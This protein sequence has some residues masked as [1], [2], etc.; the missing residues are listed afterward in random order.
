MTCI[1]MDCDGQATTSNGGTGTDVFGYYFRDR[2]GDGIGL[3]N[4]GYRCSSDIEG[5]SAITGDLDDNF[6]CES[7]LI[8]ECSICDGANLK[9]SSC[10]NP[11]YDNQIDCE[12]T[13]ANWNVL[14]DGPD[15]DCGGFCGLSDTLKAQLDECS[16]NCCGGYTGVSCSYYTDTQTFDGEYDCLGVCGGT[17]EID[18]CGICNGNNAID[19]GGNCVFIVYPGDTDMNGSV[20]LSD[21]NPIINNWGKQIPA[22]SNFD[23]NG[24]PVNSKSNWTPQTQPYNKGL[25]LSSECIL[26]ADANGDGLINIFDVTTVFKNMGQPPHS[27][28]TN[29][30]CSSLVR[31]SDIDLYFSIFESLSNGELKR[32]MA[33]M[34]GFE[35]PPEKFIVHPNYPNPFNPI[36]NINYELPEEGNVMIE[37]HNIRGQQITEYNGFGILPGYYS[38]KWDATNYP[39]GIYYYRIYYNDILIENQKMALIK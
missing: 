8:D 3:V 23:L 29:N 4:K 2:D 39:S 7:N 14:Y 31:E 28:A 15:I 19:S 34:Y 16:G 10:E 36:T 35:M 11:A 38:F 37:I 25:S 9:T 27:S 24:S 30:D 6:F 5:L 1:D 26:Y 13:L 32:K 17:T 21:L 33:E 22:R 12:T 18:D 20:N